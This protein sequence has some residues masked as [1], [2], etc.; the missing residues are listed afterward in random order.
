[1]SKETKKEKK[2]ERNRERKGTLMGL[3]NISGHLHP[4]A[5]TGRLGSLRLDVTE[6]KHGDRRSSRRSK[7][8]NQLLLRTITK[9]G[10]KL[11]DCG[12]A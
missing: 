2:A 5:G 9:P 7:N 6:D 11:R 10:E 3:E 1:M 4:Q 12:Y 8:V